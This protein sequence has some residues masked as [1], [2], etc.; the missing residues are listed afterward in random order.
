M[1]VCLIILLDV[2]FFSLEIEMSKGSGTIF[3]CND[4]LSYKIGRRSASAFI[5]C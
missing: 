5:H 2:H 1:F 3:K 4:S